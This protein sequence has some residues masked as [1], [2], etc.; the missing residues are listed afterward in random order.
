MEARVIL[1]TTSRCRESSRR[2][3]TLTD[4]IGALF[5]FW[6]EFPSAGTYLMESAA[7]TDFG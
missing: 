3:L 4:N 6:L 5:Q 1:P 7:M 2:T